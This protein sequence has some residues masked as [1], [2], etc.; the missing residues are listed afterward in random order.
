MRGP[1]AAVLVSALMLSV[2]PARAW[3]IY[4]E[5]EAS[6]RWTVEIDHEAGDIVALAALPPPFD[7]VLG[8][9]RSPEPL[10]FRWRYGRTAEGRARLTIQ[11]NGEGGIRFDF[12]ARAAVEGKRY[13]AAAVLVDGD[14]EA[15]HTFY[16][17]V[18][19]SGSFGMT[20]DLH[21]VELALSRPEHWWR[22]VRSIAF[23]T[24]TYHPQ[25]P[26]DDAEVRRAMRRAV[27]RLTNGAGTEQQG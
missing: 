7:S 12:L 25:R 23:F 10:S 5:D 22:D 15:L 8:V 17:L 1:V 27:G 26:L 4:P 6:G 16:A 21:S 14:G 3:L 9:G 20:G 18:E 13:G 19:P 11:R 2:A 24:M